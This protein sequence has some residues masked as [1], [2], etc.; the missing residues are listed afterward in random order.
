[1]VNKYWKGGRW[2]SVRLFVFLD[3]DKKSQCRQR[4]NLLFVKFA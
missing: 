2:D 1:M 4:F 3:V